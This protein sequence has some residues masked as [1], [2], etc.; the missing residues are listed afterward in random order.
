MQTKQSNPKTLATWERPLLMRMDAADAELGRG[1]GADRANLLLIRA[2][3][4]AS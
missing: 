1:G 3:I 4:N 2:G